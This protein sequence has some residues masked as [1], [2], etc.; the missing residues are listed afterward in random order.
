MRMLVDFWPSATKLAKLLLLRGIL[1]RAHPTPK[2]KDRS[3]TLLIHREKLCFNR[4][5]I[6]LF[7]GEEEK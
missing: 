1:Q 6:I 4:V 5:Q 2:Q 7:S 3:G